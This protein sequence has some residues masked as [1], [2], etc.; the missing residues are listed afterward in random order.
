MFNKLFYSA[1]TE[2]QSQGESLVENQPNLFTPP[3]G[4]GVF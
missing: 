1:G 3:A 2:Q 4:R